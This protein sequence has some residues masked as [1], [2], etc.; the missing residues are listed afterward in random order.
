M[1]SEK[2]AAKIVAKRVRRRGWLKYGNP[3]GDFTKVPR[4]EA[5][6]RRGTLCQCPAMANG[7]CRIHGGLSTGPR[8]AEGVERIKKANTTHGRYAK[9]NSEQRLSVRMLFALARIMYTPD[10]TPT[11]AASELWAKHGF[12][13]IDELIT[14]ANDPK[15]PPAIL[16]RCLVKLGSY[17]YPKAR[18]G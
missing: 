7:R 2:I 3:P 12:D 14:I 16:V 18:R 8:T 10:G 17:E 5:K 13:P 9:A 15:T 6:T 1:N 4:C 11:R